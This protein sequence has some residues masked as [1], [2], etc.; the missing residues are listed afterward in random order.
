MIRFG[1]FCIFRDQPI[2]FANATAAAVGRLERVEAPDK[3][4]RP[5]LP[6]QRRG[7]DGGAI[8]SPIAGWDGPKP[9]RHHNFINS[10]D[11][12]ESRCRLDLD[13]QV[14]AKEAFVL[15]L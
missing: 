10:E 12:P 13:G 14:E 7:A 8:S 6:G 15:R 3:L 5:A 1:L 11:F 2:K 9:G 4:G